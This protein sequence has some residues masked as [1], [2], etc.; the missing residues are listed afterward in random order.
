MPLHGRFEPAPSPSRH[1]HWPQ[2]KGCK[3]TRSACASYVCTLVHTPASLTSQAS[4][5]NWGRTVPLTLQHR[6]ACACC[7]APAVT[8]LAAE[9]R[10]G[11]YPPLAFRREIGALRLAPPG[12]PPHAGH[13]RSLQ[14]DP[15]KYDPMTGMDAY[16]NCV[17][18]TLCSCL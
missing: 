7:S 4:F 8:G 13:S 11:A 6:G 14:G 1:V 15:V 12:T 3:T 17:L 18:C 5:L 10:R 9:A 2:S 16:G